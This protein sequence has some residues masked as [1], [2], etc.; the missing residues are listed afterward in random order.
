MIFVYPTNTLTL[1]SI[2]D[3]LRSHWYVT[4]CFPQ[5]CAAFKNISPNVEAEEAGMKDDIGMQDVQYTEV[6]D[7][8]YR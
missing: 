2:C 5:G 4:G 1:N 6:R 8:G 3:I 7:T